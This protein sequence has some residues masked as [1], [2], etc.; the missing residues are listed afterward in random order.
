MKALS[1][2]GIR[3]T[4]GLS[5]VIWAALTLF[6]PGAPG[7]VADTGESDGVSA[8]TLLSAAQ[9]LVGVLVILGVFRRIVFPV[10]S[11]ILGV[12]LLAIWRYIADPLGLYL[13]TT[14]T[15]Q[16]LYFPWTTVFFASIALIAFRA[17]DDLSLG[18][19]FRS[20]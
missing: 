5:L 3:L 18:S 12:G 4:T 1:L 20:R 14:E 7:S 9:G 2:L 6:D 16:E 17:D 8:A 19:L 13:L 10:Q 15:R 11:I